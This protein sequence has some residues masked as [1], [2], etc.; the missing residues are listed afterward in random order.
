MQERRDRFH[1]LSG[2]EINSAVHRRRSE[3]LVGR[4]GSG[5]SGLI[6]LHARRVSH[7]VSRPTLDD[8]TIRR[9]RLGR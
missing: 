5:H 7:H 1:T 4:G 6:P 2:L 3:E 8:A 9:F